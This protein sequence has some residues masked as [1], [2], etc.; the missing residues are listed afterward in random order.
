MIAGLILAAGLSKRFGSDKRQALGPDGRSLLAA[1]VATFAEA[2]DRLGVVIPPGD[3]FG[4][5]ICRR[6]RAAHIVN[7]HPS[8]GQGRSLACGAAWLAAQPDVEGV[9]IGLADMPMV[10]ASTVQQLRDL[11]LRTGRPVVATYHGELGHPRGLP[12]EWFG[13]LTGLTGDAGARDLVDWSRAE[14]L[15]SDDAG[16]VSD[17]DTPEQ[18]RRLYNLHGGRASARSF[19]HHR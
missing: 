19:A 9:V 5:W 6:S 13:P 17:V 8:Q 11:L 16:V 15:E 12:R 1:C 3:D 14:S 10:N 2:F 4:Q 18:L 7:P